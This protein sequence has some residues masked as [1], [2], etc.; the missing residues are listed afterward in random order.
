M[1]E[2]EYYFNELEMTVTMLAGKQMYAAFWDVK[3]VILL[4]FL[5]PQQTINSDCHVMMLTK[6]KAQTCRARQEK[7]ATFLLHRARPQT[8]LKATEHAAI[9]G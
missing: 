7:K 9:L 6:L 2:A 5:Q 4:D 8:S 3:W 1:Y